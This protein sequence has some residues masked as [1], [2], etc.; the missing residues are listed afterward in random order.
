[1]AKLELSEE[2][3][4]GMEEVGAADLLIAVAVPVDADQLRAAATQACSA[5]RNGGRSLVRSAHRGGVSR[6]EQAWRPRPRPRSSSSR[7]QRATSCASCPIRCP[8]AV[9]REFPGLP[10]PSTYQALFGMARELGV[11]ACA[12]I[13]FDLAAL[14]VEFSGADAGAGAGEALRT[15][16]AALCH[17]KVRRPAE[18][19]HPGSAHPGALWQ[20]GAL[21]FGAGLLHFGQDAS[22]AGSGVAANHRPGAR[23]SFGRRPRL[24]CATAEYARCMW[25]RGTFRPPMA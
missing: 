16:H 18:L 3:K 4:A 22:G 13:G 24:L 5:C 6:R 2:T 12:V 1:M 11:S 9:P 17:G 7:R 19:E 23:L 25:I 14:R 15:R 20:A 21:S 8:P 10:P